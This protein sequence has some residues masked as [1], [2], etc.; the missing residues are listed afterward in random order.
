MPNGGLGT[1]TRRG[2]EEVP[3]LYNQGGKEWV[4]GETLPNAGTVVIEGWFS[5]KSGSVQHDR[6]APPAEDH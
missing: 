3:A 2:R 6:D 5:R 1:F 4:T